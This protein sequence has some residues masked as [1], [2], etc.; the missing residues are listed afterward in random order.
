M[1]IRPTAEIMI[2]FCLL[3][4]WSTPCGSCAAWKMCICMLHFNTSLTLALSLHLPTK[5][6]CHYKWA[7]GISFNKQRMDR[8]VH[9]HIQTRTQSNTSASLLP[10]LPSSTRMPT[11]QLLTF[12]RDIPQEHE[13]SMRRTCRRADLTVLVWFSASRPHT[14]ASNNTWQGPRALCP[15][16]THHHHHHGCYA[17]GL[18]VLFKEPLLHYCSCVTEGKAK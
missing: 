11:T 1:L 2:A 13:K 3:L 8:C 14:A 15:A 12:Q 4:K 18:I 10:P 6:I 5:T 9:I 16:A 17:V 7:L